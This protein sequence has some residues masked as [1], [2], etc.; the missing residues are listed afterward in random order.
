MKVY[1]WT[2]IKFSPVKIDP[3][4]LLEKGHVCKRKCFLKDE[5]FKQIASEYRYVRYDRSF[6]VYY[7]I[8]TLKALEGISEEN[9]RALV[10]EVFF[11]IY[12]RDK[13]KIQAEETELYSED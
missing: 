12:S 1:H 5:N 13:D 10:D 8:S 7:L 3:R 2:E 6:V 4:M 9:F 11:G